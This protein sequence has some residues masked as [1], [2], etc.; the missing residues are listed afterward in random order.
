[1]STGQMKRLLGI[2][3]DVQVSRTSVMGALAVREALAQAGLDAASLA[4]K[5]VVLFATSG[6]SDIGRTADKLRPYMP[7]AQ[8][9]DAR[10]LKGAGELETLIG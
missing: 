8:I 9:A 7:G 6:G 1:M 5:R 2:A 10:V 3:D 4:G